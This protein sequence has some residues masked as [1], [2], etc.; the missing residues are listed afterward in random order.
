[1]L[2][3]GVSAFAERRTAVGVRG[4]VVVRPEPKLSMMLFAV[5]VTGDVL[6]VLQDPFKMG[7]LRDLIGQVAQT[8]CEEYAPEGKKKVWEEDAFATSIR[9]IQEEREQTWGDLLV[10]WFK[11]HELSERL[12]KA[13]RVAPF[14]ERCGH[15][16]TPSPH[17]SRWVCINCKY[18]VYRQ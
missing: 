17:G 5:P 8:W 1:M 12:N 2:V 4:K 15:I 13:Y 10:E 14:C 7:I 6:E 11:D 3:Y 16:M 18:W 9:N